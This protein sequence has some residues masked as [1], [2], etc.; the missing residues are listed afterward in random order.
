MKRIF[1]NLMIFKILKIQKA[2]KIMKMVSKLT[3]MMLRVLLRNLKPQ[4]VQNNLIVKA[5]IK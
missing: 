2:L 1:K 3:K 4:L 5:Q